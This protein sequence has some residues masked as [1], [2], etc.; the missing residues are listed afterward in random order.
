MTSGNKRRRFSALVLG[1]C[2][3][4]FALP[5]WS[6]APD[7][8][9]L[10]QLM[11]SLREVKS[12]RAKFVER[13][14][15]AILKAPLEQSGTLSYQAPDRLEKRTLQPSEESLLVEG[16][17]MTMENKQKGQRRSIAL[18]SYPAA[19]AFVESIRAT[20]AGDTRALQRFYEV[21]LSGRQ[22]QWLLLLHPKE[23]NM[24]RVVSEIRIHGSVNVI[25]QIE[26]F[27]PEGD[28]SVMT[29]TQEA[30]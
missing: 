1:A 23:Q 15:M 16:D 12:A 28:R 7:T 3:C 22:G 11:Q 9:T 2:A 14:Y 5:S 10:E 30:K 8:W 4:L 19:W 13:K 29:I 18:Q 21:K 17:R 26:I 6:A 24:Q 27:E 25:H 20:M